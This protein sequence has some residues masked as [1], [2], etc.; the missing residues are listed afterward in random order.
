MA[1][2]TWSEEYSVRIKE[3]DR[4]HRQLIELVGEMEAAIGAGSEATLLIPS[5]RRLALLTRE[6]FSSEEEVMARTNYPDYDVHR[7]IHHLLGSHLDFYVER[8]ER[9]EVILNI[10][11]LD[12]LRDWLDKHIMGMDKSYSDYLNAQGV[13]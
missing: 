7:L 11:L 2:M 13:F 5:I 4:Q 12:F 9:G 1:L 6:H 10:E 3:F 8:F